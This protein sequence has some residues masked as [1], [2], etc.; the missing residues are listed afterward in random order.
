MVRA[1]W[2][3]GRR[4]VKIPFQCWP[5][6]A[7]IAARHRLPGDRGVGDT[8]EHWRG[9]FGTPEFQFWHYCVFGQASRCPNCPQMWNTAFPFTPSETGF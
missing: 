4:T 9:P 5:V 2:G 1:R 8:I 7:R 3:G 6:W